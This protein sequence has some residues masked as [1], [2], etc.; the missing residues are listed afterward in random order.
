MTSASRK[1][2]VCQQ[3]T[4]QTISVTV[5]ITDVCRATGCHR[6]DVWKTIHDNASSPLLIVSQEPFRA[7]TTRE[8]Q[9]YP[10]LSFI[11][12]L[13]LSQI[14]YIMSAMHRLLSNIGSEKK[15]SSL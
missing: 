12:L 9:Q 10:L 2:I 7:E 4:V 8:H 15:V 14:N 3:T 1:V 6:F 11:T 5:E 13:H